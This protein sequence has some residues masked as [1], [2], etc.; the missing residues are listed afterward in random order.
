MTSVGLAAGGFNGLIDDARIYNRALS[1]S[2]IVALTGGPTL[3]DIDLSATTLELTA[4]SILNIDGAASASFFDLVLG[5]GVSTSKTLRIEGTDW[6]GVSGLASFF[7][8]TAPNNANVS[9]IGSGATW[10]DLSIAVPEPSTL[11]LLSTGVLGLLAYA[12]RRRRSKA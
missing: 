2:E 8:V 9:Q 6:G 11:L 10:V 4:D 5:S 1:A 7:D 3:G 12:W